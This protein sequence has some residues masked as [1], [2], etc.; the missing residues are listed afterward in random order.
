MKKILL[1]VL[2][3][4]VAFSKCYFLTCGHQIQG[5]KAKVEATINSGFSS[6]E[7]NLTEFIKELRKQDSLLKKEKEMLNK[8]VGILAQKRKQ[9]KEIIFLMEKYNKLLSNKISERS[10]Q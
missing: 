9:E 1:L 3:I 10:L 8:Y 5:G 4:N 7:N 2:F 6:I